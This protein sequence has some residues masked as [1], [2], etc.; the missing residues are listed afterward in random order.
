MDGL[1]RWQYLI[2]LALTAIRP[3]FGQT[4]SEALQRLIDGNQRYTQDELLHADHSAD[5]RSALLEGQAP[6]AT[7]VSCSDSRVI[8][9]ILFDQG[10]GD[11]FVVRVAGNVV[12]PIELD[13]IDYSVRVLGASLIL[14]VGHE[15]CGAVNAVMEKNTADIEQ[16]AALIQPAVKKAQDLESA[17]KANVRYSVANLK[18]SPLLKRL[19][20]EKKLECVGAYYKIS[21]GTI[22]ILR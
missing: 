13:S 15:M 5:R 21:E 7:I 14:I 8:P 18:K 17:I 6:F 20:A 4:H 1:M 22:E 10:V 16:I 3:G 19:V 2:L 9:E 12:G 11:L